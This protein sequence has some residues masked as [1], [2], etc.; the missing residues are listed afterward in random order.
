MPEQSSSNM[1]FFHKAHYSILMLRSTGQHG[2][3]CFRAVL[4][5]EITNKKEKDVENMALNRLR[6]GHLFVCLF[7]YDH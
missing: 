6:K 1:Y 3:L 5:S 7:V 2:T 4:N